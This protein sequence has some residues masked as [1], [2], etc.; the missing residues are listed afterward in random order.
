MLINT[1][2]DF[3]DTIKERFVSDAAKGIN[4]DILYDLSGEH[5][6][7]W[8]IKLTDGQIVD[9]STGTVEKPTLTVMMDSDNFI[10]LQNGDL[11]G[12]K[13][14]LTRKIKVKGSIALAQKI[15]KIFPPG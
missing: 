12:R 5:A 13:A 9:I 14:F 3:F 1:P 15:N 8:A 7:Q 2:Q 11:D 10:K 6:G 4:A